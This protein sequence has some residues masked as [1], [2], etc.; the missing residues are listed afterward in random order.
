MTSLRAG[1]ALGA[2]YR[3]VERIGSGAAGDVWTAEPNAGGAVVAAKILKAEH[4][5]DPA[6][7]ER[8]VRERSVLLGLRHE[9]IVDVRDL[10]VEGSTLAIVMEYLA[11][12]SVRELLA[13][14][15][16]LAAADALALCAQVLHAL[17]VA[18]AQQVT[19][20]DIKP[21]NV[22][23]T[24][25]W[26]AGARATVRV[27]DFGIASVVNERKRETTGLL[28][29]P[30]YMAPEL[31]SH[32]R[33]TP[34]ADVYSAGVMLYELLAGRTP[35]A[36]A[37]TDFT[38]AYRHVTSR[39]PRLELPA[40]LWASVSRLLAK[41]PAERPSAAEA[42]GELT[43]LASRFHDLP[44]LEA[45]PEADSFEEVERPATMIRGDLM[46]A[47]PELP[48]YVSPLSAEA[49]EL[50]PAGGRTVLR[51]LRPS[52]PRTTPSTP[53]P[54]RTGRRLPAWATK[55]TIALAAAGLVLLAGLGVGL[56]SAF[57]GDRAETRVSA[58]QRLQATQQDQPLPTG[59]TVSRRAEFDPDAKRIVLTITYAA[60]KAALSG[61]LVQSVPSVG[62]ESSCPAVRWE[63][64]TG[65]RHQAST[66]G[67]TAKCGWTL[68][69]VT[70]PANGLATAT[71]SFAAEV[72]D[73]AELDSWLGKAASATADA[74][75]D[76]A[77][78]STAYPV[79]RL[80]DI[81]VSV[82]TRTVS[83]TPLQIALI[84]VWP[85]G[86]DEVNPLLRSPATGPPSRMLTDIAGSADDL[87][88]ADGCSGAVAVSADGRTVTALSVTTDCRLRASVG[89]FTNLE[90]SPF[91][92]T[93]RD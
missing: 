35:F 53:Q 77:A 23:L 15:G 26:H 50:G 46:P 72:A 61:S 91:T 70:V 10:V 54:E 16:P 68:D 8:F 27:T 18:H 21:D 36:G 3:L 33:T 19:H 39:P 90:S 69:G 6:L 65:A 9:S 20:R 73:A 58:T 78:A 22:L 32:G 76:A 13:S 57:G 4:A 87:R 48:D 40:P 81:V 29:T 82:P 55:K 45:L 63:G 85:S 66:T 37:G 28:G 67:I 52:A 14:H 44:P 92:I 88:F 43:R 47:A 79:Q 38:V 24:E 89:N 93:T 59:L 62:G 2:S 83:Q 71:G 5:A 60:Q 1:D 31:I 42:A 11:G 86:P 51:P 75:N 80:R 12:G 56:A 25:A 84:P 34:S 49:P 7:V 41:D 30:L 74:V 17:A 64:A